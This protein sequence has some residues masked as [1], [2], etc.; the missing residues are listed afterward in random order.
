MGND[1]KDIEEH[2]EIPGRGLRAPSYEHPIEV[3]LGAPG[4]TS[5]DRGSANPYSLTSLTSLTRKQTG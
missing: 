5:F 1:F 4:E 2:K 3:Q